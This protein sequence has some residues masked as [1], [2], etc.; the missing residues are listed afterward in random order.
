M[1]EK[2]LDL[3][4]L[5][6]LQELLATASI[7]R[8]GERLGMSQ[9]AASRAVARLREA[10]GDR[11]LVRTAKGYV[12]TPRAL[13]LAPAVHEALAASARVFEGV[14]FEPA[15][16]ART[17]RVATTDYGMLVVVAAAA[18]QISRDAPHLRLIV[19]PW[20]DNTFGALEQ[21]QLDLALYADDALP[22]DFHFRDLFRERYAALIRSGHPLLTVP[23]GTALLQG[24]PLL[25][26]LAQFPQV[27]ARYPLRR[28]HMVDDV[29]QRM[30]APEYHVSVEL[31]YFLSAPALL[32]ASDH[33][34]VL[35]QRAAQRLA[36]ADARLVS[37][38]LPVAETAF[39]Y[40]Q[41]WHERVHRDPAVQW[42]RGKFLAATRANS[43]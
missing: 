38:A 11:L 17:L 7:T 25:M 28:Q 5:R 34:M 18:P 2:T 4:L 37:V 10:L 15:T 41:I 29:L 24:R 32:I 3:N 23:R 43:S 1:P 22:P 26:R 12:P 21:G 36:A 20:N 27:V 42:L 33:V 40:R 16:S 39:A 14:S 9:P 19:E 31:P 35:P 30:G 8:A 13:A 6:L